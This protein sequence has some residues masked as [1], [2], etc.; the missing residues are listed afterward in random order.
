LILVRGNPLSD[1]DAVR[2]VVRVWKR[3]VEVSRRPP[4]E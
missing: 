2:D 4:D 1:I 3:G